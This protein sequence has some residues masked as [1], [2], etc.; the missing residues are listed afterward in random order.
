MAAD[1]RMINDEPMRAMVCCLSRRGSEA[2]A[3][4]GLMIEANVRLLNPSNKAR[5]RRQPCLQSMRS[6]VPSSWPA[7]EASEVASPQG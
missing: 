4:R 3:N 7:A 5:M 1:E 2:K 6:V